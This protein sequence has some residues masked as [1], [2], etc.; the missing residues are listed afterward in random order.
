MRSQFVL[1]LHVLNNEPIVNFNCLCNHYSKFINPSVGHVITGNVDIVK[2]KKLRKL[3][4]K[5]YT[6]IEPVY[7]NNFD[8]FGSVKSDLHNYIKIRQVNKAIALNYLMV[9]ESKF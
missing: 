3:F 5:C 6:F 1:I 7:K 9:G 4:K 8:I 2:N